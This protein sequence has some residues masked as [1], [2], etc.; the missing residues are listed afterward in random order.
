MWNFGLQVSRKSVPPGTGSR[1]EPSGCSR[2]LHVRMV[3][4]FSGWKKICMTWVEDMSG[5]FSVPHSSMGF[6]VLPF[7][8][9]VMVGSQS[10]RGGKL[11]TDEILAS[12]LLVLVTKYS[13]TII[14]I[15]VVL[16][17]ILQLF[18]S[19]FLQ[20]LDAHPEMVFRSTAQVCAGKT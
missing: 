7:F 19:D 2:C 16:G 8:K 5:S 11:Q 20:S 13:S 15:A 4:G 17:G 18:V 12:M 9:L 6:M 3:K 14:R 1:P 10:Q